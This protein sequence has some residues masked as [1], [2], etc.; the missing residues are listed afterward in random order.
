MPSMNVAGMV[1][2]DAIALDDRAVE[3]TKR[4]LEHQLLKAIDPDFEPPQTWVE[5][6]RMP[7]DERIQWTEETD[8]AGV[9][10][11]ATIE[12]ES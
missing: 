11:T 7:W 10:F 1:T 4:F 3:M 2:A 12:V 8:E 6:S 5:A 9:H